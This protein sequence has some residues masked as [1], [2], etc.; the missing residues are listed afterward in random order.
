MYHRHL[1]RVSEIRDCL[2]PKDISGSFF[3]N[4]E[5]SLA[6]NPIKRKIF[7]HIENDL[8]AL[9]MTAWMHF[10]KQVAHLFQRKDAKRGWQ[11]AFDKLNE[12]KAYSYLAKIG[13]TDLAFIPESGIKSR[14][15]PDLQGKLGARPILCEVKTINISENEVTSRRS[16]INGD[17]VASNISMSLTREFMSKLFKTLTTANLQIES[18]CT[19]DITCRFVYVTLNFDDLLNEYVDDYLAQID[20]FLTT[21]KEFPT[22]QLILN[23]KPAFYASTSESEDANLRCYA[24]TPNGGHLNT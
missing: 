16:A 18:H 7:Q 10:R 17:Y 15:T 21:K 19:D 23:S 11:A 5:Q 24:L 13:C 20:C 3:E 1:T 14:K 12:A 2:P 6:E 9:D 4:F 8:D 22:I